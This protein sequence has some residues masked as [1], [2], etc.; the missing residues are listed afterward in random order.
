MW[1]SIKRYTQPPVFSDDTVK[2][3]QARMLNDILAINLLAV[4][5][6]L[7]ISIIT[8]T[9]VIVSLL[10]CLFIVIILGLR[11]WMGRGAVKQASYTLVLLFF[12][13]VT[14]INVALSSALTAVSG[15]YIL[16]IVIAGLLLDS[17]AMAGIGFLS[18]LSITSIKIAETHAWLPPSGPDSPI[19]NWLVML[20]VFANTGLFIHLTRV[21]YLDELRQRQQAEQNA[22]K[23]EARFR[24]LYITAQRQ[25]QEMALLDRVRLAIARELNLPAII[26]I[27]VEAISDT[28][29]YGLVTLYLLKDDVLMNQYQVGYERA[30][31]N[32]P[33]DKGIS[34]RVARTGKPELV[35]DVCL[36]PDFIG[37]SDEVVSE[38]CVPL[39][40]QGQVVGV[41][42]VESCRGNRLTEAD[43]QL[44]TALSEHV[45][46]AIGR[47]RLYSSIQESEANYRQLYATAQR[48]AQ[49]LALLDRVR[50][51]IA[52]ELDLPTVIKTVVEAIADT[53]GYT[54]VSF[55][56]L[57]GD[58]LINQSQ[59]GYKNTIREIPV[60]QGVCGKVIHTKKPILLTD[61]TTEPAF[62]MAME[63]IVSE[64]CVPLLDRGEVVG[65]LNVESTHGVILTEADLLLMTA[66][67]EHVSI[68]INRARLYAA[69]QTSEERYR[70]LAETAPDAIFILDRQGKL[71]YANTTAS[72][73]FGMQPDRII[74]MEL[75]E[76]L[77]D[78]EAPVHMD[79]LERVFETGQSIQSEDRYSYAGQTQ[80]VD[81]SEERRV[82]K[83]CKA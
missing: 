36:D 56:L 31:I 41:L 60:D 13:G 65:I 69:V 22:R 17:R 23:S 67:S 70:T 12:C 26:R 66:L 27:V 63:N 80:W 55:Y 1:E 76:L 51:A 45:S 75:T 25:T 19:R 82:G 74:N 77:K 29:G 50:L 4:L 81:R 9:R 38:V 39:F 42:N 5:F 43:L 64:V 6:A 83:E 68:A 73:G 52:G 37:D 61:V 11:W 59:V 35:E 28:F 48:Q 58:K 34:G 21:R 53:F 79:V 20:L 7:V 24:Q 30:N 14:S 15:Y 10:I 16:A 2:T 78:F 3:R 18:L 71:T 46:L 8:N 40:D 49:E 32:I 57:E 33:I 47:A 72:K 54:L 44:I 62:L